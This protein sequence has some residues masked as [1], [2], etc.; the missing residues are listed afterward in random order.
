MKIAATSVGGLV[1]AE[2]RERRQRHDFPGPSASVAT[3]PRIE[4]ILL[5]GALVVTIGALSVTQAR[6]A[7]NPEP[8]PYPSGATAPAPAP[9]P[10]P[11]ATRSAPRVQPEPDPV[12]RSSVPKTQRAP[13][14]TLAPAPVPST[15]SVTAEDESATVRPS[16][17]QQRR[18]TP[19]RTQKP[20]SRATPAAK[21]QTRT[22]PPPTADRKAPEKKTTT[23]AAPAVAAAAASTRARPLALA[24]LAL[25]ALVLA[26]SSLLYL[27][28]SNDRW[29]AKT[30]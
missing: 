7:V 13:E 22:A 1:R 29:G 11:S 8:D 28:A 23:V 19:T 15:R 2:A 10:H 24:G 16:T 21:K 9:D 14:P 27:V 5:G 6:G 4:R 18:T 17:P 12:A 20:N 3:A 30:R 25:F 26:S